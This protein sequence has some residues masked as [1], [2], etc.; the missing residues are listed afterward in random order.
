MRV[1]TYIYSDGGSHRNTQI[2][3]MN[4]T[5]AMTKTTTSRDRRIPV[6]LTE[7]PTGPGLVEV[8]QNYSDIFFFELGHGRSYL[9]GKTLGF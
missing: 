8:A 5:M 1:Y 7:D 3:K 6:C 9:I 2:I 4:F